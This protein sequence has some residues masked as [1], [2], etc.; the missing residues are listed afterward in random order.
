VFGGCLKFDGTNDYVSTADIDVLT[1]SFTLWV[2][3]ISIPTYNAGLV[4]KRGLG[5][6]DLPFSVGLVEGTLKIRAG[7]DDGS[8]KMVTSNNEMDLNQWNFIAATISNNNEMKIY[9]NGVLEGVIAIGSIDTN[10][11]KYKFGA[12]S[13]G[14]SAAYYLNGYM[15]E[16]RYYNRVLNGEEIESLYHGFDYE[17]ASSAWNIDNQTRRK[18]IFIINNDSGQALTDYQVMIDLPYDSDMQS[19]FDDIRFTASDG[20]TSLNYYRESKTD[21]STA[22]FWVKVPFIPMGVSNIYAY[23]GDQALASGSNGNGTF[24][25]FED[26]S[27][28]ILDTNK[29]FTNKFANSGSASYSIASGRITFNGSGWWGIYIASNQ[30]FDKTKAYMLTYYVNRPSH[31]SSASCED[32]VAICSYSNT[33][34]RDTSYY[35]QPENGFNGTTTC[36]RLSEVYTTSGRVRKSHVVNV[37]SNSL[38]TKPDFNI[39]FH[40]CNY[41]SYPIDYSMIMFSKYVLNPP[42][43]YFGVEE[44][45]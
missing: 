10:N 21:S 6:S 18:P 36:P 22:R 27:S 43:Y 44:V 29:W 45:R 20:V 15:D 16:I 23:Y 11:Y 41:S 13:S 9:L 5:D 12:L 34:V 32:V 8:L 26:F 2:K 28:G 19:D 31:Y 35:Y 42:T 37:G 30:K 4:S 17:Y 24:L 1:G 14:D 33:V 7:V 40:G 38:I 39:E 25:L 3:P